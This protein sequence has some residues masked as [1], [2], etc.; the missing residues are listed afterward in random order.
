MP[1]QLGPTSL[2]FPCVF[3]MSVI[4]TISMELFSRLFE[5]DGRSLVPCCGMPSVMLA[6]V[7]HPVSKLLGEC[8]YQ[9]T[10]GISASIASSMP[11]AANGGLPQCQFSALS[12][13]ED[14]LTG[15]RWW[16]HWH[17]FLEQHR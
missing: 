8:I 3:N 7:N 4:R 6:I 1:G 12:S 5:K 14:I 11:F 16:K 17:P 2:V 13:S 9:T 10:N 15:R